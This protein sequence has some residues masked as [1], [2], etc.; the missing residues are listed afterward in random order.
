M[1]V[2]GDD[3]LAHR[4][5]EELVRRYPVDVTVLLRSKRLNHGPRIAE[6]TGVRVIEAPQLDAAALT[7]AG[8]ADADAV[9]IVYQDDVG[10]IHAALRAQELN[11]RVRLVI[12]MFNMRLGHGV[13]AM[14]R[15]CAVLSDASM[16]APIF[17]AA[18]LGEIAPSH[19]RLPGKTI[20]VA[21]RED[22]TPQQIVCGLADTTQPGGPTL[23]PDRQEQANLVLA[24]GSLSDAAGP[25]RRGRLRRFMGR[26]V[27]TPRVFTAA[28]RSLAGRRLWRAS[29][30]VLVLL[31]AGSGLLA[32]GG[33]YNPWEL[34]QV[35]V[36]TALGSVGS[37]D[38]DQPLYLQ[39]AQL[40]VTIAG[41]AL[42]PLLT[43]AVVEMVVTT[44][45]GA[46]TALGYARHM[47]VV[48][49]GNV[50]TRVIQQL[51]DLGLQVVAID[52]KEDARGVQTTREHDI[53]LIVG[54]AGREETL[55]AAN[56]GA[57]S[58]L[59]ALSTD[60]VVNLEAALH[61]RR[62]NPGIRVVLRLFDGDF[63]EL[64]QRSY[65][66]M[67]TRSVSFVA[68]PAFASAMLER[69]VIGTISVGR[70]VL[71][72]AEVPVAPGSELDGRPIIEAH[73]TGQVR[74]IA[75][76]P[77]AEDGGVRP[78][79]VWSPAG[80]RRLSAGDSLHVVATRAGLGR[81]LN[82]SGSV[83]SLS[84]DDPESPS[85]DAHAADTGSAQDPEPD[86]PVGSV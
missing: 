15:D 68:A 82:A 69:E 80:H 47:V 26:V 23:L 61:A 45:W 8:V 78:D 5:V 7:T 37:A 72:V 75:L 81:T 31:M 57:A 12:R 73:Q 29:F 28:V 14:F 20:F 55:R 64:V 71:L 85:P 9:A 66:I 83:M 30:W 48:G 65:G 36:L 59:V 76:T 43:A 38:F 10:N 11:P 2:C 22:V 24:T 63:A 34:F 60:D 67:V 50:G 4:L 21:R 86:R 39:I 58:A 27:D 84:Q 3:P 49:L 53:P 25:Q 35:T 52:K 79:T 33:R 32:A 17:V 18:A 1:I 40:V 46:V 6:L 16:A 77:H 54:D 70:R 42:I 74:V 51:Q 13:R 41:V 62:L 56:I 19:V 44:P